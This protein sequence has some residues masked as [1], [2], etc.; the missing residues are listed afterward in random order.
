M[1]MKHWWQK[2]REVS[3]SDR[4]ATAM[5]VV[6][7]VALSALIVV[8]LS[9]STRTALLNQQIDGLDAKQSQLTDE[10]NRTWTQ[11]GEATAPR[12]MEDRARRLGFKP[13]EKIE[14]LVTPPEVTVTITATNVFTP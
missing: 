6:S 3:V 8:W 7:G 13:A 11:I 2:L 10:I 4:Q 12:V 1:Q 14:Y 5:A 9:M